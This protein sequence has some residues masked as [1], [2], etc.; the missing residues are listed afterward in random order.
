VARGC[1][2]K[3]VIRVIQPL[4]YL[5]CQRTLCSPFVNNY[6]IVSS[7]ETLAENLV[8]QNDNFTNITLQGTNLIF[9]G[10]RVSTYF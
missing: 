10:T 9:Q 4:C 6:R 7:F 2:S 5:N 1:S 8:E 3:P